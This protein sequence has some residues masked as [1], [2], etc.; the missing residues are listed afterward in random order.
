M[1][2]RDTKGVVH[3][4]TF[5]TPLDKVLRWNRGYG[6]A[7]LTQY[8]CVIPF[9]A[10]APAAKEILALLRKLGGYGRERRPARGRATPPGALRSILRVALATKAA[11][12][13]FSTPSRNAT[14]R[15]RVAA[16]AALAARRR[17]RRPLFWS[18]KLDF[19][20]DW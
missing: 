3:P 2:A 1:T 15:R 12:C 13:F 16:A 9:E 7:G 20:L 19:G 10:G 4:E 11:R 17:R 8:Q 18:G 5:F 14:R 6:S